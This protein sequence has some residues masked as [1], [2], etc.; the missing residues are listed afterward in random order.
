[1]NRR[2]MVFGEVL[3]DRFPDGRSVLGGAPFNVAWHL[4]AF[5]LS[6]LMV[7]R[8][9]RDRAGEDVLEA[10]R[11]AG[12]HRSGIGLDDDLP[13]GSVDIRF[14]NG[15]PQYTIVRP[16]A[17]DAISVPG[18]AAAD[19]WLYHGSLALRSEASRSTLERLRAQPG[20]P[21]FVDVNLRDP[22]WSRDGVLDMLAHARWAKLNEHELAELSG[23]GDSPL[24][25]RAAAFAA[26]HQLQGL[27]VTCGDRGALTVEAGGR[28][29]VSGPPPVVDVVDTV[30]AGDAFSAVFLLGL[31]RQ[32]VV[33]TA[34]ERA[35][36][37]AGAVCTLRG[38]TPESADFYSPFLS[39]WNLQQEHER[40]V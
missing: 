4:Q 8:I 14:D 40:H 24:A 11:G 23:A 26:H 28:V 21:V 38:A 36:A 31:Q 32:W 34:L 20:A 13:T 19:G 12:M 37:F 16:V 29:T 15:E 3:F 27:L 22:W 35:L 9:G 10:M 30:G 7:S 18:D 33:S 2:P 39:D 6:P 5:G 17:W 25:E 1:M